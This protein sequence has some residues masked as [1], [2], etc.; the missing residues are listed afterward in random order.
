MTLTRTVIKITL[1]LIAGSAMVAATA[2][3]IGMALSQNSSALRLDHA[4]VSG[5][6]TLFDGT[7]AEANGYVRIRLNNGSRLDLS[8]GSKVKVFAN[9][10]SLDSGMSEIQS[11]TGFEVDAKFLK[12]RPSSA[13]AVARVKMEG[14]AVY[15]TAVNAPVDVLSPQGL[16]VSR[17]APGSPMFFKPG[18][19]QASAFESTGCVIEKS[20]AAVIVDNNGSQTFELRGADLRKVV[21]NQ[22]HVSG[23]LDL[24]AKPVSGALQVIKVGSSS[25]TSKGG[26]TPAEI[27]AN[28]ARPT[29]GP[30]GGAI[31]LPLL[32][33]LIIGGAAAVSLAA[34]AAAGAFNSSP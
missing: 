7:T 23:T 3:V 21:G 15:V 1:P 2:P 9:S 20:G 17:V 34:A 14:G 10:V 22:A 19:G 29:N 24:S 27:E 30:A 5:N 32:I 16:L 13:E 28:A 11:G 12:V 25:I 18:T 31:A 6:A 4:R 8:A 26:C 33:A